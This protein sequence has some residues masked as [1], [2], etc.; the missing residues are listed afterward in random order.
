MRINKNLVH[1][2]GD[3]TKVTLRCT[4]N[5]LSRYKELF[6]THGHYPYLCVR[7]QSLGSVFGKFVINHMTITTISVGNNS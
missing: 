3:Q 4:V 1:Q 5:Q 6:V 2:V 7:T